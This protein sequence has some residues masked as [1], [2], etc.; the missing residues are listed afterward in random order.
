[1]TAPHSLLAAPELVTDPAWDLRVEAISRWPSFLRLERDWKDLAEAAG[2]DHPFLEH[3]WLRTWWEAFGAGSELRVLAVRSGDRL[4]AVA[5]LIRTRDRLLGVPVQRLGFFYNSHV[6]RAGFLVSGA[7]PQVYEAIWNTLRS[8]AGWDVLQL[9]QLPHGSATLESLR[10]LAARDGFRTALWP[11][12]ESPY[13]SIGG[14]WDEYLGSLPAKH[15][16]NLRN[17]R[18]RLGKLGV[19]Q[20][21][22]LSSREGLTEA[23]REGFDLEAAAWKGQTGTAIA[24]DTAVS[25]FYCSLA[26][27]AALHGWLRLHFLRLNHRRIAFDYSLYYRNRLYLL[28]PGYD[29]E[30]AHLA[31]SGLLLKMVLEQ[32]FECGVGEYDFLGVNDSWKQTWTKQVRPHYWLYIFSPAWMGRLLHFGKVRLIPWLRSHRAGRPLHAW[33]VRRR[34]G[35]SDHAA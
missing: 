27:R 31:P 34:R 19:L 33:A 1:M 30:F 9:C 12:G 25:Q 3:A 29:P 2:L 23:L 11:S 20:V 13:I 17:R 16:S 22:T 14:S 4:A 7:E 28:K 35:C 26:Q 5:P 24:C 32:A 18:S 21:E 8:D 6:P 15:R 10:R